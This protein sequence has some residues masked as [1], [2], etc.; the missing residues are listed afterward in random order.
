MDLWPD[1]LHNGV[2][3]DNPENRSAGD[4]STQAAPKSGM[5]LGFGVSRVDITS[6]ILRGVIGHFPGNYVSISPR[7]DSGAVVVSPRA[8]EAARDFAL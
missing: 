3:T 4:A 7:A 8:G 5:G 1:M 2:M 6:R